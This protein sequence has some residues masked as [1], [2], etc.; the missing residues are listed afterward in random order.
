MSDDTP[1]VPDA[2]PMSY[3]EA[4]SK[5]AEMLG[6]AET[7]NKILA[8]DVAA[9]AEWKRVVEGLSRQ[10]EI[11]TGR[12]GLVEDINAASGYT[13]SA[14]VLDQVRNNTS[15]TPDERRMTLALWEDRK[16]DPEWIARL[17]RGEL[18]AKREMALI[19]INLS[20]PVRDPQPQ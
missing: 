17:N 2:A 6:D 4:E 1:V 15:I 16:A 19:N 9:N 20:L 13:L 11:Q 18:K 5:K 10:P 14:E 12:D 3:A 8:G 7:R